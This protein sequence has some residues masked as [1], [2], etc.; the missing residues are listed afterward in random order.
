ML[1]VVIFGLA[2]ASIASGVCAI[3]RSAKSNTEF[4]LLDVKL[5]TGVIVAL[6]GIVL[7]LAYFATLLW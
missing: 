2:F 7:I 6:I 4:P 3:I 1:I 5:P